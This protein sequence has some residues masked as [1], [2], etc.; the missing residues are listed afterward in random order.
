M[1]D[2]KVPETLVDWESVS[3][4]DGVLTTES[5]TAANFLTGESF[6]SNS[7]I[8]DV[9]PNTK[10]VGICGISD[11]NEKNDPELPGN[12]APHREGWYFA[13]FYLFHHLLKE[14]ASDQVWLTCV[15]PESAV[16]KYGRYVYGD[17]TPKKV[18]DR[19]VVL[20]ESM[21]GELNDVQTVSPEGLL[22]T[23]LET[24]SRSCIEAAA[25]GRPV[26]ILMFSRGPAPTHSIVMGG[27]G[28]EDSEFLTK[29]LFRQAIGSQTPEA[30][31]CLLTTEYYTGAWAI[32]PD[33]KVAPFASQGKYFESLAWPISGT[34]NQRPC[35][36]EFSHQIT[37]MLLRLHLKG[38]ETVE[39]DEDKDR[40]FEEHEERLENL[41][42]GILRKEEPKDKSLLAGDD[43]W[44]TEY[45]ERTGIHITKFYARWCLL[46]DA[47][48][49]YDELL[50]A[51]K[52][53]AEV[54]LNSFPGLDYITA[55]RELHNKLRGVV[56]GK[57]EPSCIEL[58]FLRRQIDYRLKHMKTAT[59]YKDLWKLSMENCEDF[60]VENGA[61]LFTCRWN[62]LVKI[63]E[64]H[65]IF[66]HTLDQGDEYDKG[67]WYIAS[68][69]Y[70]QG[71]NDAEVLNKIGRIICYY[72][73]DVPARNLTGPVEPI[74]S[75]WREQVRGFSSD[76]GLYAL[77]KE[78]KQYF[79]SKLRTYDC[80]S[81][82]GL[83]NY[84]RSILNGTKESGL[85]HLRG[86][87]DH[88][89]N[90]IMGTATLYKDFLG[91]DYPD[92]HEV[93]V[94]RLFRTGYPHIESLIRTYPLFNKHYYGRP[95][96]KGRT[97]LAQCI[98]T[99]EWSES[100][101]IAKLDSLVKY[102]DAP[103]CPLYD[104]ATHV[105]P[106]Y[107]HS[108]VPSVKGASRVMET[109]SRLRLSE[110]EHIR[111]TIWK[112]GQITDRRVRSLSSNTCRRKHLPDDVVE[113]D[114][115]VEE[116]VAA[117][118]G[119]LDLGDGSSCKE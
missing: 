105:D 36:P 43:E 29:R 119:K 98:A 62:S 10:I 35:G 95:Y 116:D 84:L 115:T 19:R 45:S 49:G 23:T 71:W 68:C 117:E 5:I 6:L 113:E 17:Y 93:E 33:M 91:I 55:N 56:S 58:E 89:I 64:F 81:D 41:V 24:I 15:S 40:N 44:E 75:S 92:C 37:D 47:T 65:H 52:S 27:D 59:K 32:N 30:G 21:L 87:V 111:L 104:Y 12:A 1:S 18:E 16:E 9:K 114:V 20:D 57:A 102:R 86:G 11:W 25:E 109:I 82:L 112:L 8:P 66:D 80:A 72:A 50:A 73:T 53:E 28:A 118:V 13:D 79:D 108:G 48:P 100:K 67:K 39:N 42:R 3:E 60:D 70:S 31:L 101:V 99:Q 90:E 96:Y 76:Q 38:Y 77:K 74:V 61:G 83:N 110:N 7:W 94:E 26:L 51:V 78:A 54:Y 2:W 34:I 14:V 103:T 4:H 22:E 69:I 63:L 106:K 85:G 46:K 97:Y 107:S 88:R